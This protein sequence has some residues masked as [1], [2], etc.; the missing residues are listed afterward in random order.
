MRKLQKT[1]ATT[2][3][4]KQRTYIPVLFIVP[5]EKSDE[6]YVEGG[7]EDQDMKGCS[8]LDSSKE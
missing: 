2:N 4:Y 8:P 6:L 3:Y 1:L 7:K 5:V